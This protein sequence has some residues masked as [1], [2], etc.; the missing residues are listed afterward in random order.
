[1]SH[2]LCTAPQVGND[3]WE[4]QS[5]ADNT[6]A[7][8]FF[9]LGIEGI[10]SQC[11]HIWVHCRETLLHTLHVLTALSSEK[12]CHVIIIFALKNITR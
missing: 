9:P 2:P 11:F 4:R 6:D 10:T 12:I 7:I 3:G 8:T 1:M 5:I